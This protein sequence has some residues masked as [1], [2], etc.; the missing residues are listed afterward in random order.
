M[1]KTEA[2]A[3]IAPPLKNPRASIS[4]RKALATECKSDFPHNMR[5][6]SRKMP[7][8]SIANL[9]QVFL[10]CFLQIKQKIKTTTSFK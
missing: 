6:A 3:W 9:E 8:M 5:Q 7:L 2:T 1:K 4:V 10:F